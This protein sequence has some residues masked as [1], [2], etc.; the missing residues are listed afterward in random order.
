MKE[1][2]A[3]ALRL[4]LTIGVVVG[5]VQQITGINSVFFYAPMIFEQSGIGTDAAFMQAVLVGLTNLAFTVAAM[6]LIDRLGRKPLLM[7]G[8]SG[9]A[10]CMMLLA[11]GL[12]LERLAMFRYELSSI[13]ELYR[14]RLDWL[15]EK[16]HEKWASVDL[17]RS[18]A[19][20]NRS[21]CSVILKETRERKLW[22]S[23]V[24]EA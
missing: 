10:I 15:K 7:F 21:A 17:T 16:G 14:A 20:G 2:F 22:P 19:E 9:I 4:V 6:A 3:P 18:V 13:G 23:P 5:I 11:W 8:V 1:L 24:W 12:G